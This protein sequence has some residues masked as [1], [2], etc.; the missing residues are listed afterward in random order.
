MKRV[1]RAPVESKPP[2]TQVALF[3]DSAVAF[4]GAAA[5]GSPR[6]GSPLSVGTLTLLIAAIATALIVFVVCGQYA[7][8][9][10]V[11]GFL[12]PDRGVIRV[13]PPRAGVISDVRV[14]DG[15]SVR[16]DDVLFKVADLQTLA[17]GTDAD[18]ELLAGYGD[19]RATLV[20]ARERA[21]QRFDV[22]R[23]GLLAQLATTVQQSDEA[24]RL[25]DVQTEQDALAARRLDALRTLHERGAIANVEWLSQRAQRLQT[26]EKLQTTRQL[27]KRIAG[28]GASIAAQLA[29][30]PLEHAQRLEDIGT[31]LAAIER[32][33]VQIRARRN[34]DVRAP[35]TGRIVT[36]L[37]KVGDPAR[38]GDFA[39]TLIPADS[40]LVGR[41]L[42]PS[43]AIGFVEAGQEVR[44]RFDAFPYQHFGVH[45]AVLRDVARSV[46]FDGDGFGPLRVTRPAYP[47]T[48]DLLH[49]SITAGAREVPLQSGMLLR[50]DIVLERRS[51]LEWLFEPLLGMRGRG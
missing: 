45:P 46:L 36:V 10:T 17:G 29:R 47:A 28:E 49:A 14:S 5:L 6:I 34:F 16:R 30:L 41:L 1:I 21:M 48:V 44:V 12:E 13:F 8:K 18:T 33:Q 38:P 37:R 24:A 20:S 22:E 15:D 2:A 11:E 25:L 40:T 3:R 26:S 27:L 50:A 23:E 42:I 39:L 19:E 4:R 35:V 43:S 51:I 9:E 7:R 31:R 32:A